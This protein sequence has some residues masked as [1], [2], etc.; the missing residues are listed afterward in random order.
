MLRP[1]LNKSVQGFACGQIVLIKSGSFPSLPHLK[2][3]N[4]LQALQSLGRWT[5]IWNLAKAQECLSLHLGG[6]RGILLLIHGRFTDWAL[7]NE[8]YAHYYL[9]T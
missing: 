5:Q 9:W 8:G 3:D 6:A 4:L 1:A 7:K 2:R